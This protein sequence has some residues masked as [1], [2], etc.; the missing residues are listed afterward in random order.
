[1]AVATLLVTIGVTGVPRAG[2]RGAE[3]GAWVATPPLS[4]AQAWAA[5][6]FGAGRWVVVG[7]G[8]EVA[9]SADGSTWSEVPA[10]PGSWRAVAYG[11]GRFVALAST[12]AGA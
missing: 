4:P 9:E 3:L 10:P 2:A 11:D 8:S 12:D 5:A 7:D 1:M 6:A